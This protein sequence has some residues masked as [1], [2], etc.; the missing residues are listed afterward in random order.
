ML[1]GLG[2]T[3]RVGYGVTKVVTHP[4]A[5]E[6]NLDWLGTNHSDEGAAGPTLPP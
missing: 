5:T 4:R 3:C 6:R 2:G 1:P